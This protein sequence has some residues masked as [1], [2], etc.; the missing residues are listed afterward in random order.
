MRAAVYHSNA[1]V[2]I[3]ERDVP[4]IGPGEALMRIE[5]SGICGSDVL[6][7]YRIKK[8]PIV[9]GHEVAGV[10]E[11]VGPGVSHLSPGDRV[12]ASH[13]VPCNTCRYCLSGHDTLCD[14]LR[15]TS[16]DPGGF[17]EHVR[18]PAINVDRGVYP[19]PDDVSFE[20]ASF[21]EPLACVIRAQR[22]A[23]MPPGH[24]MLVL[25]SGLAGL[26][27]VA[28]APT[29]GA[30]SVTATD[31][32][33]SR[34]EAARGLGAA[35]HLATH[36][37][38]PSSADLTIVCTAAPQALEQALSCTD[39]GGTI[40]LFALPDPG[41][42]FPM[43]MHDLWKDGITITSSYAGN[44]DDHLAA[45]SL[46]SSGRIDVAPLITH[47][48]PLSGTAEGFRLVAEARDALKVII[49]PQR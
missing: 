19:I 18:L 41:S 37:L 11:K 9:L 7:W 44:R 30:G 2:R 27:H 38:P 12:V 16:F 14:T 13:H 26:L 42:T 43:P 6:E 23:A 36:A 17:C 33:D 10:I 21:T 29:S 4:P 35:T 25:G 47:R 24:R 46:L 40:L 5:A 32:V 15:T 28:A 48:L 8:A 39:R 3:E 22:I 45:L 31:I 20:I 1:D 49:E 34:L